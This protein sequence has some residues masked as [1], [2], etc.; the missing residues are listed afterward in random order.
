MEACATAYAA[1]RG[2]DYFLLEIPTFDL[3]GQYIPSKRPTSPDKL[4]VSPVI[5]A[6]SG[7][8]SRRTSF[9]SAGRPSD[10]S[11]SATSSRSTS[12]SV[13]NDTSRGE[14]RADPRIAG[15]EVEFDEE[16][17][18]E[19]E[20][21]NGWMFHFIVNDSDALAAAKHAAFVR[22]R[23]R[24]Y[25]NEAEAMKVRRYLMNTRH[26]LTVFR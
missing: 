26:L 6:S 15:E 24:H 1:R 17:D 8:S 12:F 25:S 23:G 5:T 13:P 9:S 4:A 7:P 14:I 2:F 22:A 18:E 19:S 11:G 21:R 20:Y 10:R 16:M 3:N